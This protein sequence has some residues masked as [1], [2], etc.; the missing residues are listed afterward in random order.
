MASGVRSYLE[1][2][3]WARGADVAHEWKRRGRIAPAILAHLDDAA[4]DRNES[5]ARAEDAHD[6]DPRPVGAARSGEH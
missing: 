5:R 1:M 4:D 6:V 2:A 3:I